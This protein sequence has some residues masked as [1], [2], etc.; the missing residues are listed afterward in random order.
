MTAKFPS[1]ATKILIRVV[2]TIKL[3]CQIAIK[4]T[5]IRWMRRI[6]SVKSA[7]KSGQLSC[8]MMKSSR[9]Q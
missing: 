2:L 5:I 8:S 3:G 7:K 6:E 9:V 4:R 1:F